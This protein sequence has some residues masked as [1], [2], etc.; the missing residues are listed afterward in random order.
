M[1]SLDIILILRRRIRPYFY[2]RIVKNDNIYVNI[3]YYRNL[4]PSSVSLIKL[5][6]SIIP[7]FGQ[8]SLLLLRY[9]S[10]VESTRQNL[11]IE[12]VISS[13]QLFRFKRNVIQKSRQ[14]CFKNDLLRIRKFGIKLKA[15]HL[16]ITYLRNAFG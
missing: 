13:L 10:Y 5:D 16:P 8:G 11:S 3:G 12:F 1:N 15:S 9:S 2:Y 14:I 7:I 4:L 6:I